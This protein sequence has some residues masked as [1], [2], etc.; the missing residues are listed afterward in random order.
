MRIKQFIFLFILLTFRAKAQNMI[1]IIGTYSNCKKVETPCAQIILKHDSTF[2]YSYIHGIIRSD[3]IGNWK[4]KADTL[5]LIPIEI[6]N[7]QEVLK[8]RKMLYKNNKLFPL[9]NIDNSYN[10]NLVLRKSKKLY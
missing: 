4:F 6:E 8:L 1:N 3:F 9:S 5:Y 2:K 7:N 10:K